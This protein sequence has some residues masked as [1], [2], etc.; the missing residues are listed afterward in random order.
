[1]C[2]WDTCQCVYHTA[3]SGCEIEPA[4]EAT[5]STTYMVS[6]IP[7]EP[8]NHENCLTLYYDT[9]QFQYAAT[10]VCDYLSARNINLKK[11]NIWLFYH[12]LPRIKIFQETL[13]YI[14]SDK[15]YFNDSNRLKIDFR[16]N[17]VY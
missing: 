10:T 11:I 8:G 5:S 4:I 3:P 2:S 7:E 13:Y 9:W 14:I 6:Y 12:V 16:P 15:E 17:D 1:M